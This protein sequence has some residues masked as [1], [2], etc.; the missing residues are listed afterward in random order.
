MIYIK[1]EGSTKS[2]IR[3][4][5][6]KHIEEL[7]WNANYDGNQANI[8]IKTNNDGEKHR[9]KYTLDNNDL[10]EMLNM[11]SVDMPLHKRLQK[12]FS[13]K[14]KCNAPPLIYKVELAEVHPDSFGLQTPTS[15]DDTPSSL[16]SFT[17]SSLSSFTPSSDFYMSETPTSSDDS[18]Y[19]SSLTSSPFSDFDTRQSMN[20]SDYISTPTPSTLT[21]SEVFNMLQSPT[22]STNNS[23]EPS[24]N[25]MSSPLNEEYIIPDN[26]NPVYQRYT[27]T[28]RKRNLILKPYKSYRA[29]KKR[30]KTSRRRY[31]KRS[32]K[33]RKR[34]HKKTSRRYRR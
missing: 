33:R 20:N 1:N 30:K 28:P 22:S 2:L 9:Y 26:P 6:K 7:K 14:K 34:S 19:I 5:R 10:V 3:N 12:D 8:R 25:Y 13:R 29:Y 16:S 21:S 24:R 15:S 23:F 18:D 4:N 11:N 31:K 17:P 32:H 27:F